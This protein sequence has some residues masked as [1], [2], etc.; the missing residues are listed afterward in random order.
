MTIRKLILFVLAFVTAMPAQTREVQR[1]RILGVA[2]IA[3]YVSDL[4]KARGFYED[5]LGFEEPFSL[6]R[7]DGSVR[8]A[9]VKINDKQYVELFTDPAKNDG[10][11]NHT[12]IY[13]DNA[14]QMRD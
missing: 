10:Q 3:F 13:T 1:P 8:V 4:S 7:E 12:A 11:L 6:K 5:F 14:Q 9:F 2:H